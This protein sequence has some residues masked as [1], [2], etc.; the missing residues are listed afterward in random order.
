MSAPK[1]IDM[2]RKK[3]NKT[4]FKQIRSIDWV[5]GCMYLKLMLRPKEY[6]AETLSHA[7][8]G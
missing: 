8:Y 3:K 2:M 6:I 7:L 5:L 4:H 1:S